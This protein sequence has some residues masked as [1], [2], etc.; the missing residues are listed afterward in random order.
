MR[1]LFA[2]AFAAIFAF[3]SPATVQE[4]AGASA[5]LQKLAVLGFHR[6]MKQLLIM[7]ASLFL[8]AMSSPRAAAAQTSSVGRWQTVID[9]N[10]FD[11]YR[12]FE[13]EWHYLYP[14]GSIHNGSA[15]MIGSPTD[16]SHIYLHEGV[17][18]LK[19]VPVEPQ[20]RIH[21]YSGTIYAKATVLVNDQ[22]P[23]WIAEADI[24]ADSLR[25]T[26]P[27]FWLTGIHSWPPESDIM[28][29]KGND[30]CWQNTYTGSWQVHLT[31]IASPGSWHN[32]RAVIT[33]VDSND[34]EIRYYIDGVLT[35]TNL[36]DFVGKPMWIILD[37]QMEGSSGSPGP[38]STT[39]MKVKD[40]CV[41]RESAF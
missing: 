21:Y 11:S 37:Y 7:L 33:K 17:L 27:A 3:L 24:R 26:W 5:G 16:R 13:S 32:Y 40:V 25:G 41:K 34:V 19:S 39:Y 6:A 4:S 31:S 15:K 14:W 9:S 8:F 10:S 23:K 20:G 36:A 30:T 22:F 2:L 1:K 38:E 28:E 12:Q 35:A 18:V 29:Y